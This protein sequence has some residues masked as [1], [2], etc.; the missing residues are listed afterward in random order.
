VFGAIDG[1]HDIV[2]AACTQ[3]GYEILR[4]LLDADVPIAEI[5]SLTPEQ[6]DA[7]H[8]SGYRSFADI[9]E[10][11]DV[12]IYYPETY[13]MRGD[14]VSHFES[15]DADLMLVMG[16]QRLIPDAILDTL[17]RGALG[18]HG[19]AY[20]LPKGRGRSPMNWSL[21]EGLDRFL[22]AVIKLDS[23]ADDG[24][25]VATRKFDITPH[26]DIRTL[27]YK[28]VVAT[29]EILTETL[30]P[31]LDGEFEF[32]PQTGEAT[33]YPKRT[34]EDGGIC[35]TERTRR[36]YNLVRA[37]AAPYPGAFTEYDD[38]RVFVWDAVPFSDDFVFD[39]DPGTIVRVFETTGDFV[40]TTADGSLLVQEWEAENGEF[41]PV[42][43]R[44]LRSFGEPD[45]VDVR[46]EEP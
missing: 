26:D 3:N 23:G 28:N 12:P 13:E 8:V 38:E 22:H 37:V 14:D 21:I 45:R 30:A 5:V 11:H 46:T 42:K 17:T 20:G 32:T 7:N 35:W 33:H 29:Q 31:I 44:R 18:V 4:Y 34:P 25:I 27:Y 1:T 36:I 15:L 43:D 41:D 2:Y 39:A 9:A 24:D 40:V 16:W 10:T 19:S 6:A